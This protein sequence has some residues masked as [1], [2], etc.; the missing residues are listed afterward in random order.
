MNIILIITESSILFLFIL[1]GVLF[2]FG[3]GAFL[4]AGYNTMSKAEKE[5]YNKTALCK[6]IGKI[7]FALSFCIALWFLSDIL[8][9]MWILYTGLILFFAVIIFAWFYANTCNRFKI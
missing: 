3:K 5:K 4:I 9:I 2:S 1:L 8:K 7:M 6:F